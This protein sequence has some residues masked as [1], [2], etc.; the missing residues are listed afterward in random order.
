MDLQRV[1][2]RAAIALNLGV[3]LRTL[4]RYAACNDAPRAVMLALYHESSLGIENTNAHLSNQA[5]A[6][7]QLAHG[8]QRRLAV[9]DVLAS[10]PLL[11]ANCPI[12]CSQLDLFEL[13][14]NH[15]AA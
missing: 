11:A 6:F 4:G 9:F 13:P 3:S 8:L 1:S 12:F 14:S 7:A 5:S 15:D 2:D 10:L